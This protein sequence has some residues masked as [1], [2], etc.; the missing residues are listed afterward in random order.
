MI[1]WK[2]AFKASAALMITSLLTFSSWFDE[3]SQGYSYFVSL[4]VLF[5]HPARSVGAMTEAVLICAISLAIGYF[6]ASVCLLLVEYDERFVGNMTQAYIIAILIL[7]LTT[8]C[9]AFVRAKYSA[10]R[11]VIAT[12]CSVYMII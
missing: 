5:F 12:A 4:A 3:I 8:F 7:F 9:L 11:Q 10:K 6:I 2:P 1:D